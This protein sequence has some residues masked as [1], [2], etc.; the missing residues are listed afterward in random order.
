MDDYGLASMSYSI[1]LDKKIQNKD[2]LDGTL[3]RRKHTWDDDDSA[4]NCYQCESTF[5]LFLRRHHCR[6]CGKIFC[7]SCSSRRMAI[8]PELLSD[9]SINGTWN[10]Y[11]S[12]YVTKIE[13]EKF[14]VCDICADLITKIN[15]V[16]KVINVFNL[17]GLNIDDLKQCAKV[18][19]IWRYAANYCLSIFREIQYKLPIDDITDVERASLWANLPKFSGHSK[20]LLAILKTC[21]TDEEV[22]SVLSIMRKRRST[23]CMSLMCTRSCQHKL[24]AM[25]SINLLAH[26]YRIHTK[27]ALLIKTAIKGIVCDD[28]EFKCYLPFLV[29]HLKD[30]DGIL[31]NFI[32]KRCIDRIDLLNALYW[33]IMLYPDEQQGIYSKIMDN[34]KTIFSSRK[35]ESKFID[36]M[37]G[38]ALIDVIRKIGD[39]ICLDK[40]TYAEIKNTFVL[41]YNSVYP[42]DPKKKINKIELDSIRI[43]DSFSKPIIVPCTTTTGMKTE[44]MYK[45]DNLRKDQIVINL[46]NLMDII[47]KRETGIDL[48]IVTY[49]ILPI[50]KEC[51]I[52][53]IVDEADTVYFIQEKIKTTI[54]NYI[55]EKNSKLTIGQLRSRFIKSTA[56]YSVITYLLG[57][58]DRHLDNI[59]V[60][61]DGRLFHIDFGYILGADPVFN[62]PSIRIT[63]EIVEAVG[64]FDSV[65]YVEF[66]ELCTTIF[67]CLRRNIDIF[68]N[69]L[70]L[71][72]D[73]S[74]VNLTE[75]EIKKQIL[76]RFIPG[77]NELDAQFHLVNKLEQRSYTDRI[78]DFCH[79]HNKEN[80][81]G[82]SVELLTAALSGLWNR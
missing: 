57:V 40:K 59:M 41:D 70:L 42:L 4:T 47:V 12:S 36:L 56:A 8:P 27:S 58:G 22:I 31:S 54:L 43:K 66:K 74:E 17:I 64:G 61:R 2:P 20:Y 72:A 35:Y 53:E 15:Q 26:C 3:P 37:K 28:H 16:T 7:H 34:L 60:T 69:M 73:F 77:E 39:A 14:R 18:S 11:L 82:S 25:D 79:Y 81:I 5:T 6:L 49:N 52:V 44:M 46:I 62:N 63:P 13:L 29:Y 9:D 68:M 30:D 75:E 65:Y 50:D 1:M 24:S 19:K 10:E 76:K 80:T 55:L 33:E 32:I 23:S 67:N 51:G 38:N 71:L 48:G 78:K 21:R 45:R